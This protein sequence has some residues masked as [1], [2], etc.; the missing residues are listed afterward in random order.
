MEIDVFKNMKNRIKLKKKSLT[1]YKS[2]GDVT[3]YIIL[4]Q[5]ILMEDIGLLSSC[6]QTVCSSNISPLGLHRPHHPPHLADTIVP[7]LDFLYSC[8]SIP[9]GKP[10]ACHSVDDFK[11]RPVRVRSILKCPL[12]QLPPK[13]IEKQSPAVPYAILLPKGSDLANV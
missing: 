2:F 8:I 9:G 11:R 7:S 1:T 6:L 13:C 4:I 10:S 5:G 12:L 3:N